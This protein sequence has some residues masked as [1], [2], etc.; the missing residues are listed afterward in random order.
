MSPLSSTCLICRFRAA[1]SVAFALISSPMPRTV[2]FKS[3]R[4][5][6]SWECAVW[7][8]RVKVVVAWT[9][10]VRAGEDSGSFTTSCQ[11]AQNFARSAE[12]PSS[13]GSLNTTSALLIG[14][15]RAAYWPWLEMLW[16]LEVEEGVRMRFTSFR[17]D[18]HARASEE[19][20]AGE[21]VTTVDPDGAKEHTLPAK[22]RRLR[23]GDVVRSNI[24]R[25]LVSPERLDG[26][27]ET[28]RQAQAALLGAPRDRPA[29]VAD[30]PASVAAVSGGEV[31]AKHVGPAVA[32]LHRVQEEA[33]ILSRILNSCPG[34]ELELASAKPL[35]PRSSASGSGSRR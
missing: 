21:V 7:S 10:A 5:C 8:R 29:R 28:D 1:I 31:S 15:A 24:N 4:C 12:M 33:R 32:Q 11:A 9:S 25:E 26:G 16:R 27:I 6:S 3:W 13:D 30:S 23:V 18:A 14:V 34:P 2:W 19:I 20:V 17:V 35:T 22:A